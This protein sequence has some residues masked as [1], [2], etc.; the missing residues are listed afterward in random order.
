MCTLFRA[1]CSFR[2]SCVTDGFYSRRGSEF[3]P[4]NPGLEEEIMIH[5]DVPLSTSNSTFEVEVQE[6]REEALVEL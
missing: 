4:L 3:T 5:G 6:E 1:L 2:P